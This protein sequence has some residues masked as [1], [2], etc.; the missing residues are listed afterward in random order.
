MENRKRLSVLIVP[1]SLIL[2]IFLLLPLSVMVVYSFRTGSIFIKDEISYSFDN[3]IALFTNVSFMRVFGKSILMALSVSFFSVLLAYP[4]AYFLAFRAGQRQ[5]ALMTLIII[6][7]WTSYLLRVVA[8]KVVLGSD[9]LINSLLMSL[10]IIE[11]TLPIFLYSP[12]AVVITLV[13]VWIPFAALPIFVA[14]DRI[15]RSLLEAAADLGCAQWQAFLRVT[16]PLSLPGV[17]ASLLYVFIPTLGEYVT[18]MMVGG[19]S[20]GTFFGNLIQDQFSRGLNWQM[21]SAMSIVL[22]LNLLL[23]LLIFSRFIRSLDLLG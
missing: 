12:K 1:P 15:D 10:N 19:A 9:G 16:F 6:P 8:W 13:Y 5:V 23:M 22:I 11:E 14:L 3:Y 21:G 7:A 20:G 2:L 18:P 4:V 17:I